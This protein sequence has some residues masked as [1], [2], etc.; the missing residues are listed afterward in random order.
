MFQH[1]AARRWLRQYYTS[2]ISDLCVSTHSRPKAAAKGT[3]LTLKSWL[4]STHSR[5]KAAASLLNNRCGTL[6]SFNTQ[7]PEG[8]CQ[9]CPAQLGSVLCFN[10]QPPEGGCRKVFNAYLK[11]VAVSTHSRPKA[12][13]YQR[14]WGGWQS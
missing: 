8:G 12:A 13:A 5:P 4:V 3:D 9:F 10:T 1:T 11:G 2:A 7:P 14:Q 6:R